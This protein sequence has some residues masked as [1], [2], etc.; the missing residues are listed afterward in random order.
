MNKVIF[1]TGS[2]KGI[3]YEIARQCGKRGFHVIISGRDEKRLKK[4]LENLHTE[5]INADSLLM[6][7]SSLESI[8][9]A[10]SQFNSK[11][12]KIDVLVNNA[13]IIIKGDYKLLQNDRNILQQ[14]INTNSYGP[15]F[16]TKVFLPFITSPG[17]IVMISS[18]GGVLNGEVAGWSPAYCVSKTL[19]NAITKQLSY[20]LKDKNISVNAVCPG[21]VRTDLGGSGATRSLEKGIETPVWLSL[22]ASQELT[23]LFFRDK[24]VIPW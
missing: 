21:W 16:V 23:G 22:E 8:E 7:V 2:N 11:R 10:A 4:A 14:T 20:E 1:I 18:G 13:G 5:K 24:K 9:T 12:L 3:G 6:D 19:L 17:R 15:L